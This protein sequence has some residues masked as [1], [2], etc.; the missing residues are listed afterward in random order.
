MSNQLFAL[1]LWTLIHSPKISVLNTKSLQIHPRK[2]YLDN[3]SLNF[4]SRHRLNSVQ[5]KLSSFRTVF[6]SRKKCGNDSKKLSTRQIGF[7]S[8]FMRVFWET[9][10][11]LGIII[12][13]VKN[14]CII[15]LGSLK[16]LSEKLSFSLKIDILFNFIQISMNSD[17]QKFVTKSLN[18]PLNF[19]A[20]MIF[21]MG[22]ETSPNV[23]QKNA[24]GFS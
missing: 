17:F 21:L 11:F 24:N 19:F 9:K 3:F 20:K 8:F 5:T 13:F 6:W 18:P 7:F 14:S 10:S 16:V 23:N 12:S 2:S 22:I 4:S 15:F 1:K